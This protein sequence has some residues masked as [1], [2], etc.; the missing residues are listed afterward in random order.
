[1]AFRSSRAEPFGDAFL[2][3]AVTRL[4]SGDVAGVRDAYLVTL[5]ALRRREL[6]THE[7]ASR[8]RLTKTPAQY[9]SSRE[10]RRELAYEALLASGQRS[11]RIGDRVR[12]Y[13]TNLG[14]G[15]VADDDESDADPRNYDVDHY[16]RVL[17]ET[18]A[19]RLARAF[20]AVDFAALFA[21]PDQLSLFTR[22]LASIRPL[23]NV[24]GVSPGPVAS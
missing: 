7:V 18:Y 9:L 11:W 24:V 15:G 8:V 19:A 13:R 1:V 6:A 17:R 16:A 10:G 20:T 4:L 21:D 3:L 22:S 2:R 23:L 14:T 12:V 5:G